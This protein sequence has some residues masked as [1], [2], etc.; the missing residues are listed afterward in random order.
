MKKLAKIILLFPFSLVYGL[1]I[2]T[3]NK[4]FDWGVLR[5]KKFPVPVISVGNLSM[6]GT[7]KTP[8]VEYLIRLLK[9]H[10]RVA[11]L[12]QGYRRKTKGFLEATPTSSHFDIGDE[13]LQYATKYPDIIV[14]VCKKRTKGITKLLA[15]PEPPEVII[16]DDAF[17][18]R[19]VKPSLNILLTDYFNL[20]VDDFILPSGMLREFPSGAK[21]ADVVV[22]TKTNNVLPIVDRKIIQTKLQ[23]QQHQKLFFSYINYLKPISLYNPEKELPQHITTIFMV[24]G[25]ANP[26][27]FEKYL[28]DYCIDL[29]RFIFSDH[30]H[31]TKKEITKIIEEFDS[32]L[33]RKK[34]IVTTEKD[35]QRLKSEPFCS[36]LKDLPVYYVPIE[37]FFHKE[38][39][40]S[41][42]EMVLKGLLFH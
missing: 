11:V 34:A 6:G 39:G 7:G 20:Y 27:P 42:D 21:R 32:H 29:H 4:L 12:S 15:K 30:H 31:F 13:P 23:L 33:S 22:V 37:V 2:L 26:Y 41:F 8:Q 38:K 24:A 14:A 19:Y 17:Q 36:M 5:E 35:A 16:L 3:R 28:Q 10:K 18:H 1:I 9:E 40:A 25:I